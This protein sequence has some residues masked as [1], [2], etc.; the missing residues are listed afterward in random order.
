MVVNVEENKVIS[1]QIKGFHR[2]QVEYITSPFQLQGRSDN[3]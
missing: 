3:A 2:H 1:Y